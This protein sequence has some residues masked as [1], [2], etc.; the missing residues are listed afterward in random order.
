ML[1][2]NVN[3][4]A[5]LAMFIFCAFFTSTANRSHATI[6]HVAEGLCLH[7]AYLYQTP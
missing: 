5:E 2:A 7:W 6:S 4:Q 3:S 1:Q